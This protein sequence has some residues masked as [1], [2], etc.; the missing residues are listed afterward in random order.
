M[1]GKRGTTDRRATAAKSPPPRGAT[2]APRPVGR[3]RTWSAGLAVMVILTVLALV[4]PTASGAP[5]VLIKPPLTGATSI[6]TNR[7]TG[8]GGSVHLK[9]APF[10]HLQTGRMGAAGVAAVVSH[11]QF[12]L[13]RLTTDSG[14]LGPLFVP[15]TSGNHT[16]TFRWQVDWGAHVREVPYGSG[17]GSALATISV[18]G[19]LFDNTTGSWVDSS[20]TSATVFA[21]GCVSPSRCNFSVDRVR[22]VTLSFVVPLVAGHQYLVYGDVQVVLSATCGTI[23][24]STCNG[25]A[26][27]SVDLA[28]SGRGATLRSIAL[29]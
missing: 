29:T 18:L 17:R 16:V 24:G 27:A 1:N 22:N 4:A 28:S 12:N 8:Y 7:T 11:A 15:A 2:H 19:N 14:F 5:G 6:D 26:L 21:K 13:D 9:V 23:F 3:R 25:S 10:T 20:N